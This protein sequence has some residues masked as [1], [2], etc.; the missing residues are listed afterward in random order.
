MIELLKICINSP[1]IMIEIVIDKQQQQQPQPQ[2]HTHTH[3]HTHIYIYIYVSHQQSSAFKRKLEKNKGECDQAELIIGIEFFTYYQ[4]SK[5][6]M[7]L[8]AG[9]SVCQ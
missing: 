7:R 3:T 5:L 8:L 4:Y 6:T 9:T 1:T 2:P